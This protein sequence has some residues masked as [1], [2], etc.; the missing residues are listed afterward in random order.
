MYWF[1]FGGILCY[2]VVNNCVSHALNC[3]V[4]VVIFC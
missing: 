3:G 2:K 1:Y 4:K